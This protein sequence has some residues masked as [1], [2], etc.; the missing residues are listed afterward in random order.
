MCKILR[1]PTVREF[2]GLSDSTIDRLESRGLFP[3]RVKLNPFGRAVGWPSD[4]IDIWLANRPNA[5]AARP[6]DQIGG[7]LPGPGRP[8]KQ[9]S[10]A[11]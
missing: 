11:A 7:G 6:A 9:A 4:Q 2:T 1:R 3:A 10:A 5:K 8:K